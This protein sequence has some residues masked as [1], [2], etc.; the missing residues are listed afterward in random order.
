MET[1]RN[2]KNENERLNE[3]YSY[4]ILDTPEEKDY[5]DL[6]ELVSHL[7]STPVALISLVDRNRVWFKA[8]KGV[9]VKELPR[10][11]SV[12]TKTIEQNELLVVD[13]QSFAKK[14]LPIETPF[15]Y[16]A[17]FP[18]MSP[19]G[20]NVGTLCVI[21]YQNKNLTEQQVSGLKIIANQVMNLMNLRLNIRSLQDVKSKILQSE[22]MFKL[23]AQSAPIG[24]FQTDHTGV[25]TYVNQ[26]WC[27]IVGVSETEAQSI[28]WVAAI[29]PEDQQRFL[30]VWARVFLTKK[31]FNLNFRFQNKEKEIRWVKAHATPLFDEH[32]VFTGYVGTLEDITKEKLVEMKL[33]E[34]EQLFNLIALNSKDILTIFEANEEARC[35]YVSPSCK[36]IIGYGPEELVGLSPFEMMPFEQATI[37]KEVYIPEILKGNST[38]TENQLKKSDGSLIWVEALSKPIYDANGKIRTFQSSVREITERKKFEGQLKEEK[39]KAEESARAKSLFLSTMSHEIRT[40]MNAVIGLTNLLLTD[41]PREDQVHSL[42]LLKFSGE[43]LLA[44]L[45]DILDYNKIEAGKIELEK[46][47][48]NI[49]N[50][51]QKLVD[52]Q[53]GRAEAKGLKLNLDIDDQ[54]PQLVVGD[55]LR[56]GQVISNLVGNAIKF[57]E[58][59]NVSVVVN[60]VAQ[61]QKTSTIRFRVTDTGIGIAEEK[62]KSIFENFSQ[63]SNDITRKFG[64]TGLGLAISK[65]LVSLMDADIHVQSQLGKGTTFSFEVKLNLGEVVIEKKQK[66]NQ[67]VIDRA[68]SILLV[69]DNP[70]N[71]LVASTFL[72]KWGMSVTFANNGAEAIDKIVMRKFDAVLMDLQMPEMDGYEAT[73]RIRNMDGEYYKNVP[74]L[75]LTASVLPEIQQ[76]VKDSGF[77]DF[78]TKPFQP[79]DLYNAIIRNVNRV[80]TEESNNKFNAAA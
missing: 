78:V 68:L 15:R 66:E 55:P 41:N 64:G 80:D 12:C 71:Q 22:S 61:S 35:I 50:T 13:E 8:S 14:K 32:E 72:K 40:P 51:M 31:E 7:C 69:E 49:Q 77:N 73:L 6:V 79:N 18:L 36:E 46:I 38:R 74:V 39:I 3:L 5:N 62:Q 59:G 43:N 58:K 26:K 19:N 67:V 63:G 76:Q 45:N 4:N 65:K 16:Y 42:N 25:G 21:D 11:L 30:N 24:I 60:Q 48:F 44:L 29:H 56:L 57:T 23:L 70:V 1:Q 28:H 33:E 20:F 17:G 52:L 2:I 27:D 53:R 10:A 54:L 47:P 34:K 9:N 75:A 37:L